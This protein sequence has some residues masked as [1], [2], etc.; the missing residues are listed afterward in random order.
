[1]HDQAVLESLSQVLIMPYCTMYML[2]PTYSEMAMHL[3]QL[4]GSLAISWGM[5]TPPLG[6]GKD[7][8]NDVPWLESSQGSELKNGEKFESS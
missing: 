8:D 3:A 2:Q 7:K 4:R 6:W 1:M 5:Q